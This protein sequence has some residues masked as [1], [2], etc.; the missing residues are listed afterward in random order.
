MCVCVCV[1]GNMLAADLMRL[2]STVTST[3]SLQKTQPRVTGGELSECVCVWVC[4]CVGVRVTERAVVGGG[5]V[6]GV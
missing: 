3:G 5:G 4:V 2:Q 1:F 6:G